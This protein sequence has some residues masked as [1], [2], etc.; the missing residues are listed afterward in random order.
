MEDDYAMGAL[1]VVF[2]ETVLLLLLYSNLLVQMKQIIFF[3]RF[4]EFIYLFFMNVVFLF[5]LAVALLSRR[6]VSNC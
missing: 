4:I 6:S 3:F 5:R 1:R 2:V